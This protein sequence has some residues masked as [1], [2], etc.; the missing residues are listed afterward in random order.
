MVPLGVQVFVFE[1]ESA[2]ASGGST[3]VLL[4]KAEKAKRR[5]IALPA[6]FVNWC[7][8]VIPLPNRK[9]PERD[10]NLRQTG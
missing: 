8:A 10:S 4:A 6:F 1:T 2:A 5:E 9:L 7:G 3:Q